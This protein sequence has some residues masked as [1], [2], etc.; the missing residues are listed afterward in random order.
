MSAGETEAVAL[1]WSK[2]EGNVQMKCADEIVLF[3]ITS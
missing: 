2:K 1:Q 3:L